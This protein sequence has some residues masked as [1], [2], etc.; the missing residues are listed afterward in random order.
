MSSP[1]PAPGFDRDPWL[2]PRTP[3]A[4]ARLALLVSLIVLTAAAWIVTLQQS[5]AMPMPMGIAIRDT[6]GGDTMGD[7]AMTE[8]PAGGW[9]IAGGATFVAIWT[10]MMAAMMLPAAAPM[11]LIFA[12]AQTGRS[13]RS[14]VG[15]TWIFA[16]GYLL[17]W[18]LAGVAVYV[19]VQIGS[20]L[21]TTLAPADRAT[22]APIALGVIL[23]VAGL[24]QFTPLKGV[25]LSHCRSPLG[26]VMEHWREGRR[27]AIQMGIR[28][29]A[30]CF[31]CC[32]ALF[33]VLVAAGV[34]SLAWMLLLT[35]V[36]FAEK[37]LPMGPRASQAVGVAFVLLGV[38]V[39]IGAAGLP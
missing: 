4:R 27:G 32:W 13:G 8:M 35:L 2:R 10:V 20:D 21:A 34:M 19:I 33:A 12:A 18:S 1:M 16:A 23:I 14:A 24:Y 28:H 31:G 25:C 15:P 17:V 29:G 38:A 36:V 30:Y 11:L 26:F 37:V 22:W 3:L 39:A 6:M 5:R 9:S 7:M